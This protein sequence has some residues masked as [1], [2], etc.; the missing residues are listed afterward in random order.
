MFTHSSVVETSKVKLDNSPDVK[1]NKEPAHVSAADNTL[2]ALPYYTAP[3][4][5]GGLVFYTRAP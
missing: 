1:T 3:E 4:S 2:P 5:D